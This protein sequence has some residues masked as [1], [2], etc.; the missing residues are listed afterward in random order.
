MTRTSRTKTKTKTTKISPA[1]AAKFAKLCF[2]DTPEGMQAARTF[3]QMFRRAWLKGRILS[4]ERVKR[5]YPVFVEICAEIDEAE[6][7]EAR[8]R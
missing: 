7:R 3:L 5:L 2:T 1:E 6:R 8:G 4:V